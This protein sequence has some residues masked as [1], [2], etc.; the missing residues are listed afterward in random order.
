MHR[1]HQGFH[2][3]FSFGD[4]YSPGSVCDQTLGW[5]SIPSFTSMPVQNARSPAP[6]NTTT[7]TS[8]SA[9]AVSQMREKSSSIAWLKLFMACGRFSV[10]VATWSVTSKRTVLRS[11]RQLRS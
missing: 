3:W 5:R 2:T 10:I 11:I 4:R 6:R 8:S 7:C 1:A 9:L